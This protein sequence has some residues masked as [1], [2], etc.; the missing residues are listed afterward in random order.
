MAAADR[1]PEIID[2]DEEEGGE[3]EEWQEGAPEEEEDD[4][5]E[6][7][8][9]CLLCTQVLPSPQAALQHCANTHSFDFLKLR[10]DARLDFYDTLRLINFIRSKVSVCLSVS[11]LNFSSHLGLGCRVQHHLGTQFRV[12]SISEVWMVGTS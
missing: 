6:E 12:I 7:S 10:A 8:T 11:R 4:V 9:R 5:N 3:W 1:P 2:S